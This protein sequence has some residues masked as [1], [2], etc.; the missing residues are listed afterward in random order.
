M[1]LKL[2]GILTLALSLALGSTAWALPFEAADLLAVEPP[3]PV[4]YRLSQ[5][6]FRP[7][8]YYYLAIPQPFDSLEVMSAEIVRDEHLSVLIA[9]QRSTASVLPI[10]S[11]QLYIIQATR[12]SQ[13]KKT[14]LTE[15]VDWEEQDKGLLYPGRE[16]LFAR[17]LPEKESSRVV[18]E[19]TAERP[20]SG[21]QFTA[22]LTE[23]EGLLS[24][25]PWSWDNF[26]PRLL[27]VCAL[28]LGALLLVESFH[29]LVAMGMRTSGTTRKRRI[30]QRRTPPQF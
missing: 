2:A 19:V 22:W 7:M 12:V 20:V 6:N 9:F 16:W 29:L 27:S 13:M 30:L 10:V 4:E 23:G 15:Y 3:H 1:I 26:L 11:A 8:Y 14:P 17:F 21:W 24:G 5:V 28:V 18:E 25:Q